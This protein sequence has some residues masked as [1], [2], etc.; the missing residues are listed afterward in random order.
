[1]YVVVHFTH[2]Q[3]C[4]VTRVES[5]TE[6][7][8]WYIFYTCP[9]LQQPTTLE[10]SLRHPWSSF[11]RWRLQAPF[12]P[13]SSPLQ[14]ALKPPSSPLE[15]FR[16][17]SPCKPPSSTLQ[18]PFKPLEP[19]FGRLEAPF[20]APLKPPWSPLQACWSLAKVKPPS[21]PL[22][23]PWSPFEAPL[24]HPWSPSDLGPP[25][26]LTP[27]PS[28]P[29]EGGF[30]RG[31]LGT[32]P[33][34]YPKSDLPESCIH[35]TISTI[36][37]GCMMPILSLQPCKISAFSPYLKLELP[38]SRVPPSLHSL[39]FLSFCCGMLLLPLAAF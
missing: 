31:H 17:W 16:R 35:S 27:D 20:K 13:P 33:T 23:P 22:K 36:N 30:W 38:A 1:M 2:V 18:A 39:F 21:S 8:L 24:K 15:A 29:L 9:N 3:T 14:A 4:N 7:I 11:E 6:C 28:S 12:K 19:P 5:A 32:S 34:F 37:H 26:P 25:P 10:A